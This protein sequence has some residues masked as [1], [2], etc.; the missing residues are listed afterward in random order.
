M[1]I[2]DKAKDKAKKNPTWLL[3][4]LLIVHLFAISLNRVP[5]QTGLNYLQIVTMSGMTPFQWVA[6][7]LTGGVSGLWYGYID[8][9]GA[10][11]ESE[12]LQA[13][14]V[15]ARTQLAEAQSK[16]RFFEQL[17]ELKK[18]ATSYEGVTSRVIGRDPNQWFSTVI[19]DSGSV[20]GIE[21]DQP[22]ITGDGLVGRVILVGPIS[23]QVLLITDER[24]G[25]GAAVIGQT[26][27]SRWLGILEGKSKLLCDMRFIVP[28]DK[29]EPGEEVRT[30][31]QDGLYPA[32]LLIGRIK[33]NGTL[34]APVLVEIEPAAKLGKL[35]MVVVLK[36]PPAE[37]RGP[38]DELKKKE[39]QEKQDKATDRKK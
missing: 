10:R 25:A 32:G 6:S 29:L 31:G 2:T 5:G 33:S 17:S 16:D 7:R 21:K 28:P 9:R 13:D 14:L 20:S 22:V 11:K 30:S 24:H 8:L 39:E 18:A 37:I 3:G 1:S 26:A 12:K 19:I 38:V 34:H 23:S 35:E 27:E 15:Q 36:V 4:L